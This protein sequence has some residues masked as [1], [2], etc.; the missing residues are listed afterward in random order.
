MSNSVYGGRKDGGGE[1]RKTGHKDRKSKDGNYNIYIYILYIQKI[2]C[3]QPQNIYYSIKISETFRTFRSYSFLKKQQQKSDE[4]FNKTVSVNNSYQKS[5]ITTF[6]EIKN[7][8][9]TIIG[10]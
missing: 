10:N 7:V 1:E 5:N 4:S 8:H 6:L 2:S 9:F 3:K